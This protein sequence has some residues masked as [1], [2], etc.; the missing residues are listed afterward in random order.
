MTFA[1]FFPIVIIRQKLWNVRV[2]IIVTILQDIV[3]ARR[4]HMTQQYGINLTDAAEINI[5][6]L[7]RG[8]TNEPNE[9]V[10]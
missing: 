1:A 9:K 4:S 7:I 3:N 10:F 5:F 8:I 6:R 2:N